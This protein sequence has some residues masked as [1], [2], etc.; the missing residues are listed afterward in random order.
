M[1]AAKLLIFALVTLLLFVSFQRLQAVENDTEIDEIEE[2]ELLEDEGEE[3]T[4]EAFTAGDEIEPEED[5]EEGPDDLEDEDA[6]SDAPAVDEKDVAVLKESNF[7]DIVSKNRYVLVEFYAPWCGHCQRLVPEYAA[8]ATEL[9]GEVVLAKVD[10]TEENDLAQKFEV[11]GFPTILFFIDGVHKQYTGQ[12]TK[13]GIVSWIKRKTGPAVSNLTTTEDAETLLDSGSTAAV[14]LFDSLEGTENEEFE[15]ASRQEDDVLFYQTTSDSVAAVLGI[16]T[17][18]K[19]P[20]LV[21]LKKEPEKISHFDGKFEKAPISEFIFANKLPLVTTFTRESANMIFDSSIKKQ[22]LLFTSAKDYEKVI[23]SF[24][25]AAKL[26]KGKILFVYVESDNADVGKPIMEYFGLSGEEPKVIGCMLSEEPIKYLFEAEI[27]A[28]NIKVFGEDFLADKL[29]PFFKSDPL[30]EKNDGDVKIVVGKNFDEIV[31]DE[32]KDVLLEIYAPWCGHCQA[33]EPVY[34]KLAKQLRGVDSLV[35]AKMDGTSNEHARAKSD[36][37]P[38]IL[39]YPAGN[40]SFDPITFDDDRTVKGFYKF[41]KTNAAI[42]FKLPKKSKPESV[43]ATP[44]T[45]DSSAAEQPKDEL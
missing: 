20:A 23:P 33:L 24:Q 4:T 12:R 40:K 32:S 26:F 5:F 39:F 3:K 7:S 31:L 19:R 13:E 27:I 25:E 36:G 29:K 8:A 16:N 21:L 10:A 38:T 15:A 41:L 43:E 18:A 14:G 1:A 42:P 6:G 44:V 30:P 9:K 17:K 2:L 22:I 37:F 28:D 11:Q 34:N 45:P 35:L